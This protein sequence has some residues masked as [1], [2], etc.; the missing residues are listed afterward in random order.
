MSSIADT[1]L[2]L[3]PWLLHCRHNA[4]GQLRAGDLGPEGDRAHLHPDLVFP[5]PAELDPLRLHLPHLQ[6][7]WKRQLPAPARGQGAEDTAIRKD[8]LPPTVAQVIKAGE[9]RQSM[10]R[11]LCEYLHLSFFY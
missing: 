7:D 2:N 10:G 4:A 3:Q 11:S 9:V 5:G 8:A 6:P 1:P